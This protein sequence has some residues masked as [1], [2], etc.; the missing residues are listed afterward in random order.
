MGDLR[1]RIDGLSPEQKRALAARLLARDAAFTDHP[2][3]YG[4][5]ALW[6]VYSLDP[7]SSAYNV[8]PRWSTETAMDP[9]ACRAALQ[10]LG[11]R[12]EAL[13]TTFVEVNG[14]PVQR[15]HRQLP[16]AFT[17]VD[18]TALDDADVD[19]LLVADA[20]RPF[21]LEHAPAF[22]AML[23]RTAAAHVL[24]LTFHHIIY[25]LRSGMQIARELPFL[26]ASAVTGQ[27]AP[28]P[29]PRPFTEY[30]VWQR[31]MVDSEEG[32]R[33]AAS[34]QEHL[35][36]YPHVL[37]LPV[38]APRPSMQTYAGHA[39][40]FA[41]TPQLAERVRAFGRASGVTP[42]AVL[43]AAFY[44]WAFR[45][46]Q[47]SRIV[48]GSPGWGRSQPE[49][50]DVVGYFVNPL[51][52]AVTVAARASFASLV[53]TVRDA[54]LHGIDHGDFPF[55]LLVER[56]QPERDPSRS[57]VFQVAFTWNKLGLLDSDT[58]GTPQPTA[59]VVLRYVGGGQQGANFD[60]EL[61][62]SE[63]GEE[64]AGWWRYNSDLYRDTTVARM[65]GEWERLLSAAVA[66]PSASI[67]ELPLVDAAERER[68]L[69]H[70]NP[71]ADDAAHAPSTLAEWFETQATR[72]AGRI[73]VTSE[74][75]SLTYA[76]LDARASQLAGYL[77]T[78]GVGPDT[79]VAVCIDRS[80]RLLVGLLAVI[81]AGGAYVPIDPGNPRDRVQFVLGDSRAV[82][83]VID[84]R[85]RELVDGSAARVVSLETDRAAIAAQ[86]T[87]V[88]AAGVNDRSLAYVIYTSGSTGQPK[89]VEVTHGNATRLFT[90]TARWFAFG[91]DDVWTLFHSA[92]FDFSVWEMWGAL[93]YGG[94]VVAVPYWVSRSPDMF[95]DL[96][97]RERVTVLN[98]TPSAFRQLIDADSRTTGVP[99]ALR[100][101]IFGGEKLDIAALAPWIARHGD[102]SPRLV[103]MYGITETT[104]HVTYRP[105]MAADVSAAGGS[106]IGEPIPDLAVYLLDD[107]LEPAPVGVR[108]EIYVGGAGVARGYLGR[109]RS[110]ATRFV[111]DPFSH[112][113]G[114]RLYRSGDVGRRLADGDIEYLGRA[115]DQV[116]I[117]GFRIEP[118]EVDRV[119][120]HH[121]AVA[122]A[123]TVA[124]GSAGEDA[125]LI[126]YVVPQP[127][128]AGAVR[129]LLKWDRSGHLGDATWHELPNGMAVVQANRNETEF[130]YGEIFESG[131]YF[132]HGIS[133]QPGACV[134]D[135]GANIGMFSL[136]VADRIPGVRIHA[137][138]PIPHVARILA[139]N[140]ELH[141]LDLRAH[142]CGLA[143][144]IG[145]VTFTYYPRMTIFSGRFANAEQEQATVKTFLRNQQAGTVE[146]L[147]ELVTDR[148]VTE[149]VTCP[150][151][152][153]SE[154][155]R[156]E[157]VERI[158][159]L[160]VD[161]EKSELAVLSGIA[162]ED[163]PKI[164]QVILE[165]HDE[166]G[167]LDAV[168]TLLRNRGFQ[169]VVEQDRDLAGTPL[170]SVYAVKA[171]D[172]TADTAAA[173]TAAADTPMRS[174]LV[175]PIWRGPDALTA[176]LRAHARRMLPD[177]MVPSAFVLLDEL[178]L[179]RNG[180]LD[181]TALRAV[182]PVHRAAVEPRTPLERQIAEIWREVLQAPAISIAD[183]FFHLG[184]HSLLATR[185]VSRIRSTIGV[186]LPLQTIFESPTVEGL[187][188]AIVQRQA[189]DTDPEEFLRALADVEKL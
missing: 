75:E 134:F 143:G 17:F 179:T 130:L 170:Y 71:S 16:V 63:R 140:A 91:E 46:S 123:M 57:P 35:A 169:A 5:R 176:D 4:Q 187:A 116:K 102:E 32:L 131:Q 89:G 10:M 48:I 100:Y 64:L 76:E 43:L 30:V 177:Y 184:G 180:K 37:D 85:F 163:W 88:S 112:T 3:S 47:Q 1:S 135:V 58:A 106:V 21:D 172:T 9:D 181:R 23:L 189:A 25:D 56:L 79:T 51:P 62:I 147:D 158:D 186:E 139:L 161:V 119:L 93:L 137:F 29:A 94:R 59:G 52:L 42:Y 12:H 104:V 114:A 156:R 122:D 66:T 2:A 84:E 99:L 82:C 154:V 65:A 11:D 182:A 125:R 73:A 111:P 153:I 45:R 54:V 87:A 141:E 60:L 20:H 171:A 151:S 175:T 152:T 126:T 36:G 173:D 97:A 41:L 96:L 120:R 124:E 81:K 185:V 117:R 168:A 86:P 178:P 80:A 150:V 13:R 138:E 83:V 113:P 98:Q 68:L 115:D 95:R 157:A 8:A 144:E 49:F 145:D 109:P 103:N 142:A 22:R 18:A 77:R 38:D 105:I 33:H 90:A 55:P 26:Y 132:K 136:Y 7:Q 146:L 107:N 50:D 28:L 118:G 160:K 27:A 14:E 24:Q 34:W 72:S 188:V 19:R 40:A 155:I 174:Q 149:T 121:P 164:R 159:L 69:H 44:A 133:L 78:C 165:V 166:A 167:Q 183:N 61:A 31:Q 101:V 70:W 53:E 6:F 15:V 127:R 129:R 92:A 39:H 67:S 162:E 110:T 128:S 74:E 148:L 108:G